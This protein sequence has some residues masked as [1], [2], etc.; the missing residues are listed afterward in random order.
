MRQSEERLV[1]TVVEAGALLGLKPAAAYKAAER[2]VLPTVRF[3]RR[4]FVTKAAL[5]K[6]L[7]TGDEKQTA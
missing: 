6:L 1:L 2:G 4:R 3:G 7:T 5:E